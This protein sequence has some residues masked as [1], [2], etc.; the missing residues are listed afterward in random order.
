LPTAGPGPTGGAVD[1]LLDVL[2]Q[3]VDPLGGEQVDV[4]VRAGRDRVAG[5]AL[6]AAHEL[7]VAALQGGRGAQGRHAPAAP[8]RPG[9]QRPARSAPPRAA[10]CT[11]TRA[12]CG[13]RTPPRPGRRRG[14]VRPVP[15]RTAAPRPHPGRP[16]ART[17]LAYAHLI[18]GPR[19]DS[20][21]R[22]HRGELSWSRWS[23]G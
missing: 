22:G 12:P 17:P 9:A 14:H 11:P 13:R 5:L 18:R 16:T 6:A 20:S 15:P 4:S 1:R 2:E 21:T 8:A 19:H 10:R 23:D 7:R 3:D